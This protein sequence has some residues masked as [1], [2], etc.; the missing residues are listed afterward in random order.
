[1]WAQVWTPTQAR[2]LLADAW[3]T[4]NWS[5]HDTISRGIGTSCNKAW[6]HR[7]AETVCRGSTTAV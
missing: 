4:T 1:M 5:S 6:I 2:T 3:P 7:I